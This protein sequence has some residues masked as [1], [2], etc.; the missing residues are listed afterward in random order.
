LVGGRGQISA[1]IVDLSPLNQERI[2]SENYK[3]Q[4]NT[5]PNYPFSQQRDLPEWG[6][7]FSEYCLFIRPGNPEEEQQFLQRIAGFLQVHCQ[8]A[9]NSTVV[10]EEKRAEIIA[11]QAYYSQ[12]QLQ[13]DKTRRVLEK[14]FGVEWA[15]NYMSQVLFDAV[16]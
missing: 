4:L 7:I 1:A 13:N 12:K 10:S 14:A 6:D 16:N 11:A 2:L 8:L 5:L 9:Q 15:N 3:H